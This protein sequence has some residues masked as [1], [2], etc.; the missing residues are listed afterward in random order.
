MHAHKMHAYIWFSVAPRRFKVNRDDYRRKRRP[1]TGPFG[2]PRATLLI[3]LE[4]VRV[5]VEPP[6]DFRT[7]ACTLTSVC[8]GPPKLRRCS[9]CDGR[10]RSVSAG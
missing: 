1:D 3:F 4:L 9:I 2:H 8:A 7:S 10:R 6:G 5:P